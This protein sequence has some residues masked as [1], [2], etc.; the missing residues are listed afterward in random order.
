MMLSSAANALRSLEYLAEKGD[1][2][3]SELGRYLGVTGGTAYRLIQTLVETGFA[4]K[5]ESTRRY[6]PSSRLIIM[7]EQ[8]RRRVDVGEIIHNELTKLAV[9]VRETVNLAVLDDGKVLY[10]DKVLS[11]RPFGF[12]ARIGSRLPVHRTA[13]GRVLVAALDPQDQEDIIR[14]IRREIVDPDS[15]PPPPVATLRRQLSLAQEQG[16]ALDLG[17]YLPDISC[18]AMGVRGADDLVLGAISITSLTSRFPV[19]REQLLESIQTSATNISRS[20]HELGV[21][22]LRSHFHGF[23]LNADS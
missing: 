11:D 7:A 9:D 15:P 13:L 6:R 23:V 1:V 21:T 14:L 17:D 20:L 12:N 8:V 19:I 5:N 22:D 4:E 18:I 10:I 16:Y 2:G 3:V